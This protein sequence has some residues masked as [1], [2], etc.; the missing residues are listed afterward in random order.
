M[1]GGRDGAVLAGTGLAAGSDAV[2]TQV[3]LQEAGLLTE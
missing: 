3:P 1:N 2:D